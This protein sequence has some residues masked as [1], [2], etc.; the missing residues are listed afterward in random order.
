MGR[1][2]ESTRMVANLA[3][4]SW[5]ERHDGGQVDHMPQKLTARLSRALAM[6]F[7]TLFSGARKVFTHE[8][9]MDVAINGHR[10]LWKLDTAGQFANHGRGASLLQITSFEE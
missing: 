6:P 2:V 10:G 1:G 8:G 7:W 3:V 5:V 4:P 9:F